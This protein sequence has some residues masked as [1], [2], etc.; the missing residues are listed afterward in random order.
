MR[1]SF[2]PL[3]LLFV[4]LIGC[5]SIN[6]TQAISR[7]DSSPPKTA[8]TG[9]KVKPAIST[10]LIVA[11]TLVRVDKNSFFGLVNI[12]EQ[13]M[14]Y[15]E[16]TLGDQANTTVFN[17]S[18]TNDLSMSSSTTEGLCLKKEVAIVSSFLNNTTSKA[19]AQKSE[20]ILRYSYFIKTIP[21]MEDLAT[22]EKVASA[23]CFM[24]GVANTNATSSCT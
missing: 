23:L 11:T 16:R 1:K 20:S 3:F 19:R 24:T 2:S 12:P 5:A 15:V 7:N 9:E 10:E 14:V 18:K 4:V 21:S 6:N 17:T 8:L 22:K 13:P